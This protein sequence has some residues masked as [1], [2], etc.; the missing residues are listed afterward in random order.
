M[1][2]T[3][4]TVAETTAANIA[5]WSLSGVPTPSTVITKTIAA[6]VSRAAM[7]SAFTRSAGARSA[8][9]DIAAMN[10]VHG[11]VSGVRHAGFRRA[12]SIDASH[13]PHTHASNSSRLLTDCHGRRTIGVVSS[14]GAPS[15][16]TQAPT[17]A[18]LF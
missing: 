16:R 14:K 13:A 1:A 4:T 2:R 18:V 7:C 3:A 12:T 9:I 8:A 6:A 5:R 10:A 11:P 15:A 17:N